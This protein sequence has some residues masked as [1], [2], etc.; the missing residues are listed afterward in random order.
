VILF[1]LDAEVAHDILWDVYR[2]AKG[3]R[4]F[5]IGVR[6]SDIFAN[7][8]SFLVPMGKQPY[9]EH[10]G[11]SRWFYSGDEFP[12]VQLVWP[13]KKGRFPWDAGIEESF[14]RLQPDITANGWIKALSQ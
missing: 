14:K 4:K 9:A 13:D 10:L 7:V 12:C 1:A 6:V 11:W 5:P 2:D 3:G 8:E